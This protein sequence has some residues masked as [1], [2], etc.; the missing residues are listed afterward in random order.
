MKGTTSST[1]AVSSLHS[2]SELHTLFVLELKR[3]V[4]TDHVTLPVNQYTAVSGDI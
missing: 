1:R 4:Q 3:H 2:K